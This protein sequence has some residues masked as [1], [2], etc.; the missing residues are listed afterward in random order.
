MDFFP[1]ILK[2]LVGRL[3]LAPGGTTDLPAS[4]KDRVMRCWAATL[5]EAVQEENDVDLGTE[6][7][8]TLHRLHIN[9]DVDFWSQRVEDI[10]PTL[11]SPL[12]PHLVKELLQ[13]EKP[14]AVDLPQPPSQLPPHQEVDQETTR[15]LPLCQKAAQKTLSPES[16]SSKDGDGM[17]VVSSRVETPGPSQG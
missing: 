6:P 15:W 1:G 5:R 4:I 14:Q 17:S 8:A 3:G 7:M 2:G 11:M 16:P 10:A 12:L 9:Y 13:P